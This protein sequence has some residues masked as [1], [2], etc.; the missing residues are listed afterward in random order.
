MLLH[1]H[2][3]PGKVQRRQ[4]AAGQ[5]WL[6]DCES[7][8][9]SAASERRWQPQ[10]GL[11]SLRR[12]PRLCSFSN[13]RQRRGCE[14]HAAVTTR[15]TPRWSALVFFF[16]VVV[17]V[18]VF[19]SCQNEPFFPPAS[20]LSVLHGRLLS[21]PPVGHCASFFKVKIEAGNCIFSARPVTTSSSCCHAKDIVFCPSW[22]GQVS[23]LF[24]N[25]SHREAEVKCK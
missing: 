11:I 8:L 14:R 9:E 7:H 10:V 2:R 16:V 13:C 18:V 1:K 24:F 21:L 25:F 6:V 22:E 12:R 4:Q 20:V 15:R 17:V 23:V 19:V 3:K 5:S